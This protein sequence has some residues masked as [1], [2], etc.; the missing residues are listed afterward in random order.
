M[1]WENQAET[2]RPGR[3]KVDLHVHTSADP[4]DNLPLD[5]V[6]TIELAAAHGYDAIALTHHE[7]CI[8]LDKAAM[9]ASERTGVLVIP[10][11]EA[12]VDG[13]AHVLVINCGMEMQQVR[14]LDDLARLRRDEPLVVPAHPYYPGFGLGQAK[15]EQWVHLFDG[16]EWCHFWNRWLS[17]PNRR[18]VEFCERFDKPLVATGDIHLPDQIDRTYCLVEADKDPRS[19][20]DAVRAGRIET[21]TEPMTVAQMAWMFGRLQARNHLGSLRSWRR[22]PRVFL[23]LYAPGRARR[24]LQPS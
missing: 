1:S 8:R 9:E 16:I 11:I 15:L 4:V 10:G 20:V 22:L 6:Q 18:A 23:D 5:V 3:L 14:S 21:V 7:A 19:I 2:R 13:G 17:R 24:E 12:T